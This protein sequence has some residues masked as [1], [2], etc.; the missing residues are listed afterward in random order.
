M[1]SIKEKRDI[2]DNVQVRI[3]KW[4]GRSDMSLHEAMCL[5]D[6]G[7]PFIININPRSIPFLSNHLA[8]K[9]KQSEIIY[10][11]LYHLINTTEAD[12]EEEKLFRYA[13]ENYLTYCFGG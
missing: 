1:L 11:Q 6:K 8:K 10:S 3:D 7:Y 13:I 4:I 9:F 5:K 12:A 2:I